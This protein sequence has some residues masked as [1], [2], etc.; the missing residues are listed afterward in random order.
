MITPSRRG[1]LRRVAALALA[2]LLLAAAACGDDGDASG[3]SETTVDSEP[4]DSIENCGVDVPVGEPP[5]RAVTMNQAATEVVL[6]LGLEDRMV[7]TAYLDDEI[8]PELADA[9]ATV[10]VLSDAYPSTEVLF[11]AEPDFVYGSYASA[12]REDAAG[13]RAELADLGIGTYLSIGGCTAFRGSGEQLDF[14]HVFGEI[15]D[16]A[17]LFGVPERGEELIAE[18]QAMLG[19]AAIPDGADIS[20]MWWDGGSDAPSIGS[21]CGA[22][23]M[24]M[25]TLG[26]ANVYG[27]E[28]GSWAT[29]TW[30]QVV[31]DDPDVIVLVE[32]SWDPAEE[33]GS[34]LRNDPALADLSAVVGDR[35]V[36]IPFSGTT[37]GVRN[38]PALVTLAD[39]IRTVTAD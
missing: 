31:A 35:L 39:D 2:T 4:P 33:K 34:F 12:F 21:C 30:E 29:I 17:V 26:L 9:Y 18:Q 28:S 37:P 3:P 20:V 38:A 7:G 16:I 27:T 10:A 6:A 25:R 8:L 32:A 19:D 22:P 11:E 14:D 24:M 36:V 5:E 13:E 23:G 15:R 1:A